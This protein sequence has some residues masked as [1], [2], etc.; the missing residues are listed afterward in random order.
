MYKK[1]K[2]KKKRTSWTSQYQK[3]NI[4]Y[5]GLRITRNT[6]TYIFYMETSYIWYTYI[7]SL[8]VIVYRYFMSLNFMNDSE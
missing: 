5:S 1:K 2:E 6:G 3:T 7:T 8:I 4:M